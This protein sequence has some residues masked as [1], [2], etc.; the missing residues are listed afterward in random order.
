[1]IGLRYPFNWEIC[2]TGGEYPIKYSSLQQRNDQDL[3]QQECSLT[4][5]LAVSILLH[6]LNVLALLALLAISATKATLTEEKTEVIVSH[7]P[8]EC[9]VCS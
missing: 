4:S 1:M 5:N 2:S 9:T 7:H 3:M 8:P 6:R